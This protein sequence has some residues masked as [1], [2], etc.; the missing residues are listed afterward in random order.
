MI[1]LTEYYH[2]ASPTEYYGTV[3]AT[4]NFDPSKDAEAIK[5]ALGKT[6]GSDDKTI[7]SV[8]CNRSN[9]QRQQIKAAYGKMYNKVL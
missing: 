4:S 9:M 7:I 8:V 3:Y 2:L 6:L 5:K 1:Y